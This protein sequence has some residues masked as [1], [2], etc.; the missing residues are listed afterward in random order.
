MNAIAATIITVIL[1]VVGSL[2]L[3]GYLAFGKAQCVG[4][5]AF[6]LA[7][8]GII[9]TITIFVIFGAVDWLNDF[10]ASRNTTKSQ[11]A[12][13]RGLTEQTKTLAGQI[14]VARKLAPQPGPTT[15]P[16]GLDI[17][18]DFFAQLPED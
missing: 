11:I 13:N 9:L 5:N 16:G 6:A 4:I 7:T 1:S 2:W 3:L 10:L 15:L 17:P 18:S 14:G 8:L 12:V